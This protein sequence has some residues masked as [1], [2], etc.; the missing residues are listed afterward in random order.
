[1]NDLSAGYRTCQRIARRSASSFYFSFLLLPRPKRLA[2]YA[3]YAFLRR[4]DDLAD[5]PGSNE[6]PVQSAAQALTN[7]RRSL[8]AAL[9]GRCEGPIWTALA[10]AVS[11]YQIP[12]DCLSDAIDGVEMDLHYRPYHTFEQLEQYCHRVASSVGLACIH[13]WGFRDSAAL[14]P[15]RQCGLAFQL[16]NIL[17]DLAEDSARGRVY[18]PQEDLQRCGYSPQELAAGVQNDGFQRLM[19]LELARTASFFQQAAVLPRY[20]STD[21]QRIFAAMFN[22]YWRLYQRIANHSTEV[23][24][25]RVSLSHWDKLRIAASALCTAKPAADVPNID[26]MVGR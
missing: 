13:I 7:A 2:M 3:L 12:P 6:L 18:L 26:Q 21:G 22:T 17:R 14:A 4:I 15:A 8:S 16:T 1:M 19:D 9:A 5:D 20:L 23:L 25:R 24:S 10:D 11:R